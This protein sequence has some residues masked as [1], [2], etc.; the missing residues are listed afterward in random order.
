MRKGNMTLLVKNSTKQ[1]DIY[2]QENKKLGYIQRVFTN[3]LEYI[4]D[5]IFHNWFLH[6]TTTDIEGNKKAEAKSILL[7]NRSKWN[8]LYQ[9]DKGAS[10][11]LLKAVANI[12]IAHDF[13][14][15]MNDIT[16]LIKRNM[17]D[18]TAYI[19][20]EHKKIAEITF[21]KLLPPRIHTIELYDE[22]FNIFLLITL[23][24]TFTLHK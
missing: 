17:L 9:T 15:V 18:H 23:Y 19:L 14:F 16:Y 20:S 6:V 2:N 21:D 8:V 12:S 13:S 3:K 1:L 10:S 22:S 5:L 4:V 24:H 7:T 11:L